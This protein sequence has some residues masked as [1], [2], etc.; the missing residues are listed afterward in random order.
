MLLFE[1]CN[2]NNFS[3][4]TCPYTDC[5]VAVD[6]DTVNSMLERESDVKQ[7]Y[8]QQTIRDFILVGSLNDH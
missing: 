6:R 1:W 3:R 5:K 7:K 8:K 4:F 2:V